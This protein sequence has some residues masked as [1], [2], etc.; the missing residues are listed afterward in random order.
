MPEGIVARLVEQ[1]CAGDDL[2]PAER[3]PRKLGRDGR[4]L[5]GGN[6][7]PD[8]VRPTDAGNVGVDRRLESTAVADHGL[9]IGAGEVVDDRRD[10]HRDPAAADSE[11]Q[12]APFS[13]GEHA[14]PG[15]H[16]H[17]RRGGVRRLPDANTGVALLRDPVA[18]VDA[19]GERTR[20]D[21]SFAD[22]P[23]RPQP[24]EP[25]SPGERATCVG[26]AIDEPRRDELECDERA[27]VQGT[28][29]CTIDAGRRAGRERTEVE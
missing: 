14:E 23:G 16:E 17:R 5:A 11:R 18:E 6:V 10:V 19:V 7:E 9:A 8:L 20:L 2:E 22:P 25:E 29:Q 3:R 1:R 27:P 13:S 28:G 4:R 12:R 26:A 24:L 15:R 21:A